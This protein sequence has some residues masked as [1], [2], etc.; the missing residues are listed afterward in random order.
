MTK[1]TFIIVCGIAAL[2]NLL[3]FW[4]PVVQDTYYVLIPV[5]FFTSVIFLCLIKRRGNDPGADKRRTGIGQMAAFHTPDVF[6][7]IFFVICLRRIVREFDRP[8]SSE[9]KTG[10]IGYTGLRGDPARGG[11]PV[12]RKQGGRPA[13]AALPYA[14]PLCRVPALVCGKTRGMGY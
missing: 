14:L 9:G 4:I 6:R 2:L 7:L 8:G 5:F 12:C 1:S 13:F 11:I 10:I 3:V